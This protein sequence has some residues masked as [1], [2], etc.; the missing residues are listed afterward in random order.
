[1]HYLR[2]W[3]VLDVISAAPVDTAMLI[4]EEMN[5]I[6]VEGMLMRLLRI[7]RLVKLFRV[8]RIAR[9]INR[10]KTHLGLSFAVLSLIEFLVM[11]IVL[12]HWL[13]CIYTLI[14]RVSG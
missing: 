4:L 9:I 1:M 10:W 13:A 3:F 6:D 14:G 2:S 11:T 5:L 7:V 12:A 8:V